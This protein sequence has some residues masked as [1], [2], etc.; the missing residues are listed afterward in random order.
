MTLKRNM[1]NISSFFIEKRKKKTF[2]FKNV[3]NETVSR[4]PV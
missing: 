4:G 3:N 2:C 1:G